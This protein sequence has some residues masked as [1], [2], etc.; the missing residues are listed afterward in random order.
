[1]QIFAALAFPQLVP[2]LVEPVTPATFALE[3]SKMEVALL[4][5]SIKAKAA[6]CLAAYMTSATASP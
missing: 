4:A 2:P 6:S 5:V 1:M 3:W